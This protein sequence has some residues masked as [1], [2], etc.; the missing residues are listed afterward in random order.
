M[1]TD[2]VVKLQQLIDQRTHELEALKA[3]ADAEQRHLT[4]EE[5]TKYKGYM[6]DWQT[7]TNELKLE[8]R[9]LEIRG[10]MGEATREA[11]KPGIDARDDVQRRWA[12]KGIVLPSRD[13]RFES[14]GEQMRSIAMAANPSGSIDRRLKRAIL[15]SNESFPSDG[16]FLLQQDFSSNILTSS[17]STGSILSRVNRMTISSNSNSMKIPR[18]KDNSESAGIFGGIIAYWLA[19]AADKTPTHPEFDAMTLEL[20]K[21]AALVPTTDDLLSDSSL[22]ESFVNIGATK[23]LTKALELAIIRGTGAGSPLGILNSPSLVTVDKETGQGADTIQYENIKKMWSRMSADS[24]LNSVWLINQTVEPELYGMGIIVGVGG[25]PVYMPPNGASGSPYG[26]LFGRPVIPCNHCSAVGDAGDIILA[27]F[28]EYL[29]IEKGGVQAASSIH[30]AFLTDQTY[31]RFVM[32]VDGQPAWNTVF[33]PTYG[34]T[35]TQSP[36]VTLAARA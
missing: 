33:T 13:L 17:Y 12:E 27:D 29:L 8:R 28:S 35:A 36:F 5:M 32:R 15:G 26:T 9:E 10:E 2:R 24:R 21:V 31:F 3:N 11:V 6:D 25:S 22:L 4:D 16:G 19:E 7:Y 18:T 23:A 34:S 30:V 1:K 14:M 20:K